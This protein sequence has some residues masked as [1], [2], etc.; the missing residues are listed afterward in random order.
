VILLDVIGGTVEIE[1]QTYTVV[2]G[3]ALYATQHD[4]FRLGALAVD[5]DGNIYKLKLRG[6]AAGDD[7]EFPIESGSI[8][9]EFEGSSGPAG[10]FGDWE[11]AMDGTVTAG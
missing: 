2:L 3:Y 6:S 1:N 9:L 7:A 5:G 10:Q 8:E 4:V 11:L